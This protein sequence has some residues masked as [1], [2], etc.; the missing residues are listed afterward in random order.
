MYDLL[1][2]GIFQPAMLVYWRVLFF[3][4]APLEFLETFKDRTCLAWMG[5]SNVDI[6][7][8]VDGS[9]IR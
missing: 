3:S 5:G 1:N 9:E 6:Q 7:H 4:C 2:M 8:T